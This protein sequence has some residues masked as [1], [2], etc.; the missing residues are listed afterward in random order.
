MAKTVLLAL[1]L[2]LA[3]CNSTNVVQLYECRCQFVHVTEGR[4]Q[5]DSVTTVVFDTLATRD[6][7]QEAGRVFCPTVR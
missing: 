3:A 5:P 2:A 4:P 7:C 1:A 6:E